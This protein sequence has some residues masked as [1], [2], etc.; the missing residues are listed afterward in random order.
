VPRSDDQAFREFLAGLAYPCAEETDNPAY[1][2][3]L[4]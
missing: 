4:N 1:R 3:F 2:L